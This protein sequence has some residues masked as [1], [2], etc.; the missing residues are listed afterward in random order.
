MNNFIN[1]A[2][3]SAP[4][5]NDTLAPSKTKAAQDG[6]NNAETDDSGVNTDSFH[7]SIKK[8]HDDSTNS[9]E[10]ENTDKN[11]ADQSGNDLPAN[12]EPTAKDDRPVLP[13]GLYLSGQPSTGDKQAKND[14]TQNLPLATKISTNSLSENN[15]ETSLAP[16]ATD[17]KTESDGK[18]TEI[19]A[20]LR[21]LLATEKDSEVKNTKSGLTQSAKSGETLGKG[22]Q[23]AGDTIPVQSSE[24]LTLKTEAAAAGDKVTTAINMTGQQLSQTSTQSSILLQTA[25]TQ[26]DAAG[27]AL[28][29]ASAPT[30]AASP[31]NT[32]LQPALPQ[33]GIA[34][35]FGRPAWAQ[36]MSKQILMMVNQN[37]STAEIRL[38]P[39]H[40][41]PIEMLIDMKDEQISVSMSSRHAVVREAMEQA[42]PKLR[43][44]LEQNGFSLADTDISQHSFAQQREQNPQNTSKSFGVSN[45]DQLI[46]SEIS[47]QVMRQTALPSSMVDYY[48]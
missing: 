24:T 43:D 6:L 3:S 1:I 2:N 30:A 16:V 36:G 35:A 7:A 22:D 20:Q 38:N 33:A 10:T 21:Q 48:I 15:A 12:A 26:S 14:A 47:Q 45:S 18:L 29:L 5:A 34:E 40:L 32:N 25:S 37:I 41:G 44:M 31:A 9:R 17:K 19:P 4:K 11:E 8:A 28:S 42:L 27:N 39:A 23:T 46:S 13:G